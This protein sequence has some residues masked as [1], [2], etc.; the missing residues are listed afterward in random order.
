MSQVD[1]L[2]MV[3]RN[4]QA[5]AIIGL[6]SGDVLDLSKAVAALTPR[7]DNEVCDEF[8]ATSRGRKLICPSEVLPLALVPTT[9][10]TAATSGRCLLRD[11][12]S[13]QLVP[14]LVRGPGPWGVGVGLQ[15]QICIVDPKVQEKAMQYALHNLVA[16]AAATA[17]VLDMRLATAHTIKA[18]M[19]NESVAAG[20]TSARSVLSQPEYCGLDASN[21][22]Q[23]SGCAAADTDATAGATLSICHTLACCMRG[24]YFQTRPSDCPGYSDLL[25]ALLPAVLRTVACAGSDTERHAA[26]QLAI[27]ILQRVDANCSDLAQ[28]LED[29][30]DQHG[31]HGLQS[32][33]LACRGHHAEL[34]AI[35][36]WNS[37]LLDLRPLPIW[38]DGAVSIIEMLRRA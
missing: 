21:A 36:V 20:V 30:Y 24:F 12:D 7:E 23:V 14:L 11:P 35:D 10:T 3:A 8:S 17:L 19:L 27:D 22:A 6:G 33:K 15:P 25:A 13:E 2:S 4:Y 26:D 32:E 1:A 5:Q 28:W 29:R 9:A 37:P 16:A 34:Y 31:F 38:L 18:T